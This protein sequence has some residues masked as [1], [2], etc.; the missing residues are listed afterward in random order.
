METLTHSR[1]SC[2]RT[3]PWKH[4]LQYEVGLV[5]EKTSGAM[6]FGSLFH[7]VKEAIDKREPVEPLFDGVDPYMVASVRAAIAGHIERYGE[8]DGGLTVIATEQEFNMPLVNPE[9]GAHTPVWDLRGKQDRIVRLPDN[10]LALMEYKTTSRDFSPGADYWT[11]LKMDQQLS[12]YVAAARAGGY[13]IDTVIYDVTRRPGMKPFKATPMEKRK[14]NKK[15]GALNGKQRD[16]D[17]TPEEYMA[18]ISEDIRSRPE[19]Y[20]ARKEIVRTKRD[21]LECGYEI[22][23][24]QLAIRS[25][26]KTNHWY[27]NPGACQSLFGRCD[28]F[29]ICLNDDI[30]QRT[31]EGFTLKTNKHPEL[32]GVDNG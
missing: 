10:R 2:F 25:A 7:K 16:K 8:S 5:P 27:R 31:P 24:Q 22:W 13:P 32:E 17:E 21:L 14:Y 9:T 15:D 20:Y 4:Y 1:M 12:I 30:N 11:L 26:Q 18:R 6:S 28:Y 23:Q 3:C 19:Y 29:P